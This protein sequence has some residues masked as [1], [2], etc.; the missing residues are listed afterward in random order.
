M[1]CLKPSSCSVARLKVLL[2]GEVRNQAKAMGFPRENS[3]GMLAAYRL[4]ERQCVSKWPK[5]FASIVERPKF[6]AVGADPGPDRFAHFAYGNGIFR[7]HVEDLSRDSA[8]SACRPLHRAQVG[9]GEII[10]VHGRPVV[11][12]IADDSHTSCL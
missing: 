4:V 12:A 7:D 9:R 6:D 1:Q 3:A 11:P 5:R 2:C 8:I 10:D